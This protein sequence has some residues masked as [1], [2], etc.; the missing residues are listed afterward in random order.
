M[1]IIKYDGI[2]IYNKNKVPGLLH[3]Y[4]RKKNEWVFV[5]KMILKIRKFCIYMK[6]IMINGT[7]LPKSRFKTKY[8]SCFLA[9]LRAF[10]LSFYFITLLAIRII[11]INKEVTL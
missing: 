7:N 5:K 4:T 1:E 10:L 11:N 9:L 2:K 8:Y 6:K 3:L